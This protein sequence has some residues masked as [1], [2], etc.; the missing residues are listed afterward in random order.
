MVNPLDGSLVET[1]IILMA[2]YYGDNEAGLFGKALYLI[3]VPA[4][5][6]GD[7]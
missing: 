5:V 4:L 6:V 3:T 1:P 7:L 2:V